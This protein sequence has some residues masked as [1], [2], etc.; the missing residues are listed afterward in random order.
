MR[1]THLS[2][3]SGIGGMDL[4]AEW[5]GFETIGQVELAEYPY[6]VLCKHWPDVKKWRDIRHVKK[7]DFEE[8]PTIITGGFPCQPFSY[9]GKRK[10]K[11]DDR[12]LWP[13]MFRVIA[14][15]RP[16][17][18]VGENVAGFARVGLQDALSD[19]E[20]AGYITRAFNIPAVSVGAWHE[21][22][23]V[24]VVAAD[25]GYRA[26]STEQIM[27]QEISEESRASSKRQLYANIVSNPD[28]TRDRTSGYKDNRIGK[29]INKGWERQPFSESCRHGEDIPDTNQQRLQRYR[30]QYQEWECSDQWVARTGGMPVEKI[31]ESEPDVGRVANGIPSRVDRLKCLGN[32]VV[33]QQVYPILKCIAEILMSPY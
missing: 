6:K 21:R 29:E 14:E 18:V 32:A 23:R 17:W 22:Q 1:L 3:F 31:W 24:F 15:L 26:R 4:A 13:E 28:N 7:E 27:Q 25:P 5:A 16:A 2:L 19:L 33:P 20:S 10:G 30:R 8:R 12:Y 11:A 9:A